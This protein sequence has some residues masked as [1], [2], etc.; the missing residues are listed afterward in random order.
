MCSCVL[1][2]CL[3]KS[4]EV[5]EADKVSRSPSAGPSRKRSSLSGSKPGLPGIGG[6]S[7]TSPSE[8]QLDVSGVS[9]H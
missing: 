6:T 9:S 4:Q 7:S 2:A 3:K 8:L 5:I 1:Q